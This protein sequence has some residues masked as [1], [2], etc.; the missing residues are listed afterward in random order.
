MPTVAHAWRPP[1]LRWWRTFNSLSILRLHIWQ[2]QIRFTFFTFFIKMWFV[3]LLWFLCIMW[4]GGICLSFGRGKIVKVCGKGKGPLRT[5]DLHRITS[6]V[7]TVHG[8]CEEVCGFAL[9]TGVQEV[10]LVW[11]SKV[12]TLEHNLFEHQRCGT[13]NCAAVVCST[14]WVAGKC[15]P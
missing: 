6:T 2:R 3:A 11:P 10:H 12:R 5:L 7:S 13:Q 4:L 9:L 1:P 8:G 15:H 14:K